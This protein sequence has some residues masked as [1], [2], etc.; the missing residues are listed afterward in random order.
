MSATKNIHGNAHLSPRL[1][2]RDFLPYV[3]IGVLL[4]AARVS[5]SGGCLRAVEDG[6]TTL[7]SE[8]VS[9]RKWVWVCKFLMKNRRLGH[10][11]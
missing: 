2:V 11:P 8:P 3:R 6:G 10:W 5:L 7:T 9:T 4:T 1:R